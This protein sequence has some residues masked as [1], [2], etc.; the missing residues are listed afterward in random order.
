MKINPRKAVRKIILQALEEDCGGPA[1]FQGKD[2]TTAALLEKNTAAAARIFVKEP[3]VL[4]G[5]EV[6]EEVFREVDKKI[7]IERMAEDGEKIQPGQRILKI[8]G[9]A[10]SILT[11][12]RTALNFLQHLSG[13]A[14]Q[15]ARYV[16]A[17]KGTKTQI[18][19][20]RKTTPGLRALEKHA[21]ACGGGANHRMGLYDAFLIK[22][23]HI[24]LMKTQGGLAEA[25]RRARKFNPGA[26]LIVEADTLEQAAELAGLNVDQI[27]LDNMTDGQ[28]AEAVRIVAGRAKLEASGNMTLERV[29]A[30]AAAGVDY[31]SVGALT[32][33]I[34]ALDFSLEMEDGR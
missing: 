13:V 24:H 21:V 11:A 26:K 16:E 3:G 32:H 30:A 15:T 22:D 31:I 23:N 10:R 1:P 4:A 2:I 29:P 19:D 9:P 33:H 20:T 27:L 12:E 28:L 25:V 6:A 34:R 14:T 8:N 18:L 5:A 17:L 7:Q